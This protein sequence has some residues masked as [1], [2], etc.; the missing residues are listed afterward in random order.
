MDWAVA[1]FEIF[2]GVVCFATSAIETF[3]FVFVDVAFVV[4]FLQDFLDEFF[5]VWVCCSYESVVFDV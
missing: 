4:Y 3:V 5:V 1:V 2:F